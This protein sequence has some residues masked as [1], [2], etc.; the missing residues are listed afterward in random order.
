MPSE[1]DIVDVIKAAIDAKLSVL[2]VASAGSV[3][4]YHTTGGLDRADVLPMVKR[5]LKTADDERV[6]EE[7]ATLPAIPVLWPRAGQFVLRGKLEKGDTGLIVFSDKPWGEW[8]STGAMGE[9][10]DTRRHSTGY[11]AFIPG[12]FADLAPLGEPDPV[13]GSMLTIGDHSAGGSAV[14]GFGPNGIQAG[15]TTAQSLALHAP[16]ASL[17]SDLVT[18][19]AAL[20]SGGAAP[21]TSSALGLALAD[22]SASAAI[23]A[24]LATGGTQV[25]KG[26]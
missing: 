9:P 12:L 19:I 6:F 18:A 25:L 3:I 8:L 2:A 15:G 5:P 11:A 22:V 17:A 10:A 26:K 7:P 1:V 23:V 24:A 4:K 16:L 14:M 21:L 20:V 13:P